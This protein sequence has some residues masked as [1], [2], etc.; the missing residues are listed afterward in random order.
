MNM[1]RSMKEGSVG[2]FA[3]YV[4][5]LRRGSAALEL[6][7]VLPIILT[8]LF[9]LIWLGLAEMTEVEVVGEARNAAWKKR[10]TG[11]ADDAL[12]FERDGVVEENASRKV[13]FAPMFDRMAPAESRHVLLAGSW[14]FTQLPLDDQPNWSVYARMTRQGASDI[15]NMFS[16]FE[17]LFNNAVAGANVEDLIDGQL[18]EMSGILK[19][20][21]GGGFEEEGRRN[22]NNELEKQ[23]GVVAG[24]DK[25]IARL[26]GNMARYQR[27]DQGLV[28]TQKMLRMDLKKPNLTQEEKDDLNRQIGDA[29][30]KLDLNVTNYQKDKMARDALIPKRDGL[31]KQLGKMSN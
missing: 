2:R 8:F 17:D 4:H 21:R 24:Y 23:R 18:G 3:R 5:A 20:I 19:Q 12:R 26:N 29:Q 9:I 14:D 11:P 22:K 13:E 27:E 25:E 10:H 31:A 7:M 6:V 1:R 28:E 30:T 16:G 15:G